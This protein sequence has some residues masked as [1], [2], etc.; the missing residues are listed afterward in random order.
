MP[1][2]AKQGESEGVFTLSSDVRSQH[3]C[4]G[5]YCLAQVWRDTAVGCGAG[6]QGTIAAQ[7]VEIPTNQD[8]GL[9]NRTPQKYRL[10]SREG[11]ECF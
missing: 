3:S 5:V 9:T 11:K 8:Q 1:A 2:A 10:E 4:N 6:L 7:V